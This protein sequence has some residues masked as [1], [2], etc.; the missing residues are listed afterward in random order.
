MKVDAES[1]KLSE[2][3]SI[4]WHRS[5]IVRRAQ[6]VNIGP[7]GCLSAWSA[8]LWRWGDNLGP[9][10]EVAFSAEFVDIALPLF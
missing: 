4:C 9:L 7:Q 5:F 8:T 3:I 1:T 2:K 10:A 6:A